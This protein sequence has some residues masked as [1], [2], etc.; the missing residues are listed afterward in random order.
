VWPHGKERLARG[1]MDSWSREGHTRKEI[2]RIKIG[3]RVSL[4]LDVH[5]QGPLLALFYKEWEDQM[6]KSETERET[7]C[8][9]QWRYKN[10]IYGG[11]NSLRVYQILELEHDVLFWSSCTK[12][13]RTM[14]SALFWSFCRIRLNWASKG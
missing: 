3:Y 10:R 9:R 14:S 7:M 1:T 5:G 6:K 11:E 12:Y 4:S 13:W 8:K 2:E